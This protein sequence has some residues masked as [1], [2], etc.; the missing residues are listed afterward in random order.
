MS[1]SQLLS[2]FQKDEQVGIKEIQSENAH[3]VLRAGSTM[4]LDSMKDE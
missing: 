1:L 2:L 3:Q 4:A